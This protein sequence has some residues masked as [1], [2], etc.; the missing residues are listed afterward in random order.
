MPPAATPA[1]TP[2]P[3]PTDTS[4]PRNPVAEVL[5]RFQAAYAPSL[6]EMDVAITQS[7]EYLPLVMDLQEHLYRMQMV[8]Q[9]PAGLFAEV[10]AALATDVAQ[11]DEDTVPPTSTWSGLLFGA[12]SGSGSISGSFGD[13]QFSCTLADGG[14]ITGMLL[15]SAIDGLWEEYRE[16][17]TPILDEEGEVTGYEGVYHPVCEVSMALAQ[18]GWLLAV[19]W[20]GEQALLCVAEDAV[21][22]AKGKTIQAALGGI[23]REWADWRFMQGRFE[24]FERTELVVPELE[25][26]KLNDA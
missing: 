23:A 4:R 2:A 16:T 18:E 12:W 14:R 15:G 26:D 22:F 10:D 3:T 7:P 20:R 21:Y 24:E 8:L 1:A 9:P 11:G 17:D 19:D 5:D 25:G 13:A 6:Q